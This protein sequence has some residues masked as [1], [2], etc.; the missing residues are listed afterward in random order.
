MIV[1]LFNFSR[2][3]ILK[4]YGNYLFI[5]DAEDSVFIVAQPVHLDDAIEMVGK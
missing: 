2:S 5:L 4:K 1:G 3:I